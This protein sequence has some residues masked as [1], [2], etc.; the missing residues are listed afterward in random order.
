MVKLFCRRDFVT[1]HLDAL[2]VDTR[3]HVLD[4]TVIAGSIHC[5]QVENN[6]PGVPG[7]EL[8]LLLRKILHPGHELVLC[9]LLREEVAGITGIVIFPEINLPSGRDSEF[10]HPFFKQ[11]CHTAPLYVMTG[12]TSQGILRIYRRQMSA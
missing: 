2:R 3:H 12:S 10:V 7:K 11:D 1:F 6:G 5:L 4:G 8:V 9:I